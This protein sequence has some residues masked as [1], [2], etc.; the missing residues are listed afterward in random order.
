MQTNFDFLLSDSAADLVVPARSC[1]DRACAGARRCRLLSGSGWWPHRASMFRVLGNLTS[2]R[3]PVRKGRF[4]YGKRWGTT[5]NGKYEHHCFL[6]RIQWFGWCSTAYRWFGWCFNARKRK[7]KPLRASQSL[8]EPLRASQSLSETF[9]FT[10]Y[11]TFSLKDNSERKSR[12]THWNLSALSATPIDA[13]C[14][15]YAQSPY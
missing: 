10:A 6:Y 8:S 11:H 13:T 1:L 5:L 9:R 12:C 7:V 14:Y 15:L 2:Y 4:P 3:R